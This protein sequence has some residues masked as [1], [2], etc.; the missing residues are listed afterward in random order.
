M[1]DRKKDYLIKMYP[2]AK[3]ISD[4]LTN[5]KV[6]IDPKYILSHW[7]HETGYGKNTGS[8]NNNHA[9]MHAYQGSPHG[10]N[11]KKY[12][13]IMAFENA[14]HDLMLS[15]RYREGV[16]KSNTV[17]DFAIGLSNGGYAEDKN[18][19]YSTNWVESFGLSKNLFSEGKAGSVKP[20]SEMIDSVYDPNEK[21]FVEKKSK[22]EWNTSKMIYDKET[23]YT[24]LNKEL[25]DDEPLTDKIFSFVRFG[26]A[27]FM[28][29][30]LL[31]L[32]L[33]IVFIH[34]TSVGNMIEKEVKEIV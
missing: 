4:K 27:Q 6:Y 8:K 1:S 32:F 30:V 24:P 33:Y 29:F 17:T 12:I 2:S 21:E 28:I 22:S 26:F 19:A 18:Y 23:G 25:N 3:R 15:D 10:I 7:S 5:S 34:K 14:Y 11:G 20:V 13:D 31:I 9:G 16:N